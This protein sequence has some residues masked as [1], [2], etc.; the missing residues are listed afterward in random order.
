[1]NVEIYLNHGIDGIGP[2]FRAFKIQ[3]M[4]FVPRKGD[5]IEVDWTEPEDN[6]Y[7]EVAFVTIDKYGGFRVHLENWFADKEIGEGLE[8]NGWSVEWNGDCIDLSE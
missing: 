7:L 4:Q 8:K 5:L 1:M 6:S 3:E 2:P